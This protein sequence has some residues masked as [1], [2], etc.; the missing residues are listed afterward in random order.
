[1]LLRLPSFEFAEVGEILDIRKGL[2]RSLL[3]F[4]G[5][6]IEYAKNIQTLPWDKDFEDECCILY[7]KEIVPSILEIKEMIDDNN[8]LKN[9]GVKVMADHSMLSDISGLVIGIA[10][11]GAITSFSNAI[12]WNK[13]MLVTGGTWAI[14]KIASVYS[15]YKIKAKEIEI[16]DLYFYHKAGRNLIDKKYK[17]K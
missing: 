8:I 12:A 10:A 1:M 7:N 3:K 9:L 15:N 5:K 4:R 13:A 2:E 16:K 17:M 14:S 6:S 11:A